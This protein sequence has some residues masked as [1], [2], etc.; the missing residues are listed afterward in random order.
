MVLYH[1]TTAYPYLHG[2][3]L[4]VRLPYG[5]FGVELFFMIS[6][7]V[8]FMTL[9]RTA[10][11]HDFAAARF[12]RLYPAFLGSMLVT[13][14]VTAP[15]LDVGQLLANLAMLPEALGERPFDASYWT[16]RFEL[17]FYTVAALCCLG[18]RCRQPELPCA[19]WLGAEV[20]LCAGLG[21]T[22]RHPVMNL[23]HTSFA[24]LFVIGVMLYRLHAGQATR[25]TVALLG[26]ALMMAL[27]G[28]FWSPMPLSRLA[29]GGVI[30][31]FAIIVWLAA[32]RYGR[33]LCIAPLLAL[34]RISYS[35][36]LVH[37][38][39]GFVLLDRLQSAGLDIAWAVPVTVATAVAVAWLISTCIE[40][41]A[42]HWL[43]I[44]FAG[45][46]RAGVVNRWIGSRSA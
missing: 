1:Y 13:L 46:R 27:Y 40:G 23:T 21:L 11:L 18:L 22:P 29:Y 25:L 44:W 45:T 3:R 14:L 41:P 9:Q 2:F 12:A 24:H 15:P 28:P 17:E 6:G 33:I 36:Y 39:A 19:V 20:V 37:Q 43:R 4:P 10:S 38:A 8:I 7:F 42:Q 26:L 5:I 34:G 32:S 35:L 30:A 16:L 31:G